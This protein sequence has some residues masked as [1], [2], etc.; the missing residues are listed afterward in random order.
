MTQIECAEYSDL[1]SLLAQPE[2]FD[3]AEMLEGRAYLGSMTEAVF[4][5]AIGGAVLPFAGPLAVAGGI[6][7][8]TV[9]D[10]PA[11]FR[12]RRVG[13]MGT[14]FV[15]N[16]LTTMPGAAEDTHSNGHHDDPRRS[17]LGRVLSRLRVDEAPNLINVARREMSVIGP[18]PLLP[19]YLV[20]VRRYLGAKKADE[21]VKIRSL[22]LPGIFDEFSTM[23]HSG[24]IEDDEEL[25]LKTRV[26]VESRYILETASIQEDLRILGKTF[27]L[28]GRTAIDFSVEAARSGLAV[29]RQKVSDRA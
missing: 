1:I 24:E 27:E 19:H 8:R 17:K 12:Q 4:D 29:V 26:E 9:D 16:K 21:W 25:R 2:L 5:Y 3:P 6:A 13:R 7:V 18:R 11:V 14:L 20:G 28:F 15:I 10:A 22:A 23:H